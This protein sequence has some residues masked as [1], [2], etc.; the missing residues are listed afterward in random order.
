VGH[1]RRTSMNIKEGDI[2]KKSLDGVDFAVKKIVNN[3][4][5][6]ESQDR[7]RQILTEVN[8]LKLK[9]F[10]LKEERKYL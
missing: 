1:E 7:S 6:L 9:T 2:F 3:M 8:T 5:I 10:Y 4:A